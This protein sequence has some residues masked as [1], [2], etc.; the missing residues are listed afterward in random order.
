MAVSTLMVEPLRPA[1]VASLVAHLA[2]FA[3]AFTSARGVVARTVVDGGASSL[4]QSYELDELLEPEKPATEPEP[5]SA[6][7]RS[8]PAALAVPAPVKR[9]RT[10]RP[11]APPRDRAGELEA[12]RARHE[13]PGESQTEPGG[14]GTDKH[15]AP[16]QLSASSA[17]A[18]GE[19]PARP[20]TS[21]SD[22][23]LMSL[24][25]AFAKAVTAATHK[26]PVWDE[27]PLGSAGQIRVVIRVNDSGKIEETKLDEKPAPPKPLVTLVERTLL[28]LKAGRFAL[29]AEGRA[30]SETLR[31]EVTLS[32]VAA[33][34][35]YEDPRH[36][37]A[38]GFEPPAPGRAGRSYFVHAAGR[39]FDAK[40]TV[41]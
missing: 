25:K 28:L 34:E 38:M 11:A 24:P 16:P 14:N 19:A 32:A 1:L 13:T 22:P 4:G 36:T 15:A 29:K 3:L 5:P 8:E 26:D 10:H 21:G 30:G 33:E 9:K 35:D 39:R 27:L 2:V 40:I 12:S 37:V 7:S 31:I 17:G 6:E 20:G 41:E 18:A 23:G